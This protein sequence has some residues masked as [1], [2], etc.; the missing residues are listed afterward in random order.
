MAAVAAAPWENVKHTHNE[1]KQY[2]GQT[3]AHQLHASTSKVL[4]LTAAL[5]RLGDPKARARGAAVGWRLRLA[6]G[7]RRGLAGTSLT[8]RDELVGPRPRGE[9]PPTRSAPPPARPPPAFAPPR[10]GPGSQSIPDSFNWHFFY[11]SRVWLGMFS[12]SLETQWSYSF[13]SYKMHKM[14]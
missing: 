12:C 14:Y 5:L 9:H 4:P 6:H 2:I 1:R 3:C 8:S 11:F 7:H 13:I 10:P